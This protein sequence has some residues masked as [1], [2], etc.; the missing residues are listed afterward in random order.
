M[1]SVILGVA[2]E[3][4]TLSQHR[5][6][7]TSDKRIRHQ[8]SVDETYLINQNAENTSIVYHNAS[9]YNGNEHTFDTILP[10]YKYK[11]HGRYPSAEPLKIEIVHH[12][13][14]VVPY[15]KSWPFSNTGL[16]VSISIKLC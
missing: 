7:I 2:H 13:I 12:L 5:I 9:F 4:D 10:D 15:T 6:P 14:R 3:V 11:H 8:R 1:S 16:A